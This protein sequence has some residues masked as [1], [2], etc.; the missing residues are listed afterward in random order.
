MKNFAQ[1]IIVM[2]VLG[3]AGCATQGQVE[4]N[5]IQLKSMEDRLTALDARMQRVEKT[6]ETSRSNDALQYCFINGQA[7]SEG[8]ISGG[9]VCERQTGIT[10]F[11]NG[12]PVQYPLA[13]KAWMYK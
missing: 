12:H 3:L 2:A 8:S 11:Q 13:W 6:R 5:S 7:F 10:V 9:R 4:V 1:M